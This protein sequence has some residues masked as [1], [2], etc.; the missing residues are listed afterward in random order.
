[1]EADQRGAEPKAAPTGRK[2][3]PAVVLADRQRRAEIQAARLEIEAAD[4]ALST[5]RNQRPNLGRSLTI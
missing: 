5:G 1:M 4:R 3:V 2:V